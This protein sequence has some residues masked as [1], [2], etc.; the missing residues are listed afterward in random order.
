MGVAQGTENRIVRY[1]RARWQAVVVTAVIIAGQAAVASAL[2]WHPVWVLPV[3]SA[4][5][6]LATVAVYDPVDGR[7][8]RGMKLLAITLIIV[9]AAVSALCL[10]VLL[11]RVF[12]GDNTM[13]A[14]RLLGSG[15]ALWL[16]N[17][18][19]FALAY[20]ELDAGG[21]EH[22]RA[23]LHRRHH[24]YPDLVFPQQQADP[25]MRLAPSDWRPGFADYLFVSLTASTAFS[26]TDTMPWSRLAKLLM[27]TES[28]ISFLTFGL[29]LASAINLAAT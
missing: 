4:V 10:A 2:D 27:G 15:L 8:R 9:L 12:T 13:T 14:A 28:V 26:P 21:P 7:P 20:W 25:A 19:V 5:L 17:L 22:R 6:L 18:L 16:V 3:V 1:L 29:L 11:R 24:P 23:G